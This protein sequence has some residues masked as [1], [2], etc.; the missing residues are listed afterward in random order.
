MSGKWVDPCTMCQLLP[1][2]NCDGETPDGERCPVRDAAVIEALKMR[3]NRADAIVDRLM[4][5]GALSDGYLE[6]HAALRGEI[7]RMNGVPIVD[8]A[9]L[10]GE[11]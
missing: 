5:A 2:L 8:N 3:L 4:D 7:G 6:M 10:A 11:D 9:A 1:V